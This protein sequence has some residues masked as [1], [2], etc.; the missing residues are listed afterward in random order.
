LSG[1]ILVLSRFHTPF[2]GADP[3]PVKRGKSV[4]IGD[5]GILAGSF[6]QHTAQ[7]FTV[8]FKA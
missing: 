8:D 7:V 6:S 4:F 3:L 5:A 1:Q 2:Q